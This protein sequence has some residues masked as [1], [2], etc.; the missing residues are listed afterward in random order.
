MN[1]H[2]QSQIMK[3]IE[4]KWR[5]LNASRAISPAGASWGVAEESQ[6]PGSWSA[7]RG[8]W[9]FMFQFMNKRAVRRYT[10]SIYCQAGLSRDAKHHHYKAFLFCSVV[11]L[12][13]VKLFWLLVKCKIHG[14]RDENEKEAV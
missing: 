4:S 2:R 8:Q 3:I 5:F 13:Y 7:A 12:S 6:A 11:F 14:Q 10:R 1:E 9:A